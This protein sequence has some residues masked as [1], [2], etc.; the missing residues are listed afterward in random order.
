MTSPTPERR[1]ELLQSA[2]AWRAYADSFG[3]TEGMRST[4]RAAA[5]SI[6]MEAEDGIARCCCCFKPF[7]APMA[8]FRR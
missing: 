2:A 7:G 5:K 8:L 4:A 6:E 3:I 1:A